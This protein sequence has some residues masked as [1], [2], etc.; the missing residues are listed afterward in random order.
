[1]ECLNDQTHVALSEMSICS[2]ST[3]SPR[4]AQSIII[5]RHVPIANIGQSRHSGGESS[6]SPT[7]TTTSF[8]FSTLIHANFGTWQVIPGLSLSGHSYETSWQTPGTFSSLKTPDFSPW[9]THEFSLTHF[10]THKMR[11]S[12][13]P[14]VHSEI[15]CF[16]SLSISLSSFL[17][18][19]YVV[20]TK[21]YFEQ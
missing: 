9:L 7:T 2:V 14:K 19:Q 5:S 20:P 8:A 1:V 16:L 10:L 12:L 4:D 18:L 3:V 17:L 15:V 13:K 6:P 11:V 21:T